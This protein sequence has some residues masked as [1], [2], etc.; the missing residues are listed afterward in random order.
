MYKYTEYK[1]AVAYNFEALDAVVTKLLSEG[2]QLYGNPYLTDN[3]VEGR[4]DNFTV[5]QAMVK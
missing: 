1:T 4:V 3:Q 2:F 5:A